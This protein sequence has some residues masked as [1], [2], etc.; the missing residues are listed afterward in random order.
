M[1]RNL[2]LTPIFLEMRIMKNMY[3]NI[4]I[5]AA[6]LTLIPDEAKAAPAPLSCE[7]Q[8]LL[9][10]ITAMRRDQG[11]SRKDAT[12]ANTPDTDLTRQEVK[13]ILDRVYVNGKNQT[14]DQIKDDVY[15]RC[16]RG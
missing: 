1:A 11:V 15:R 7:V 14:P 5:V 6:A 16:K 3:V 2:T 9:T 12:I 4:G 8:M 10:G 13:A